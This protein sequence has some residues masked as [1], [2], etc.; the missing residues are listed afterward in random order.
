[1]SARR[2]DV[3]VIGS[4]G[5]MGAMLCRRWPDA[6]ISVL[7]VERAPGPDGS[8][9]FQVEDLRSAIPQGRVVL[10]C[11]PV[12]V[13]Q[14]TLDLIAPFMQ[15]DQLLMDITSVKMLPMRWMQQVFNGPVIGTHPLFGPEPR[16]EDMRV[17]LV[18]GRRARKE[19]QVLAERLF[20]VLGCADFWCS[21]KEHDKGVGFAQSLNFTLSAAYFCALARQEGIRPFLTPSFKRHLE[22]AR[23]HL[24]QDT[25]M[26]CEFSA[27]NPCFPGVLRHYRRIL[28]DAAGGA[29]PGIAREAAVWYAEEAS[30]EHAEYAKKSK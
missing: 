15:R 19:H 23:K 27:A 1:M 18:K 26:F 16:P 9:A 22:S 7:G 24:T 11:V 17:A 5:R 10:L 3:V 4:Q 2:V 21:G 30:R 20:R 12:T 25:A 28:A 8:L 14:E 13:L 29:L 6:G